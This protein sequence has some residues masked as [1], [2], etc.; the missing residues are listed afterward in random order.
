LNLTGGQRF[1]A[2]R[3]GLIPLLVG[4]FLVWAAFDDE[5]SGWEGLLL[6]AVGLPLLAVGAG[7]AIAGLVGRASGVVSEIVRVLDMFRWT[8]GD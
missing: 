6:A 5:I 7:L 3:H 1:R 2:V 4:G 8:G